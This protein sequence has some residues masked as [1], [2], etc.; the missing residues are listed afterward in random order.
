MIYMFKQ[1]SNNVRSL[2]FVLKEP[3]QVF[4]SVPA[5]AVVIWVQV[6]HR[7]WSAAAALGHGEMQDR[8]G[9]KSD[10]NSSA[11][12]F[13]P[14]DGDASVKRKQRVPANLLV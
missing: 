11:L 10:S 2:L 7:G 3:T 9:M 8:L 12:L 1:S 4:R 14:K 6:V 5:P 13:P